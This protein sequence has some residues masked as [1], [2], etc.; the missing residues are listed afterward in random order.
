M[1]TNHSEYKIL[2]D[3][4]T[5]MYINFVFENKR[6][7]I[8]KTTYPELWGKYVFNEDIKNYVNRKDPQNDINW[9]IFFENTKLTRADLSISKN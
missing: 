3:K 7:D 6:V 4:K 1:E 2:V 5:G 9:D 8:Q